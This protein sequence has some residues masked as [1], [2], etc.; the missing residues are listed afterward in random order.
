MTS[1][2]ATNHGIVRKSYIS[3]YIEFCTKKYKNK[4]LSFYIRNESNIYSFYTI[5]NDFGEF[6]PY[7]FILI[8]IELIAHNLIFCY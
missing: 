5:K 3:L 4:T 8:N 1:L 6:T 7:K 2:Y